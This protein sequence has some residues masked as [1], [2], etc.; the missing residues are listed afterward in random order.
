M[1]AHTDTAESPWFDVESDIKKHAR[2]NTMAHLLASVPYR[3]VP[4]PAIALPERPP[5]RGYQRPPREHTTYVPDHAA[6]LLAEVAAR[7][8]AAGLD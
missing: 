1:M 4:K 2:L 5:S 6:I 3:A 7:P 8:G